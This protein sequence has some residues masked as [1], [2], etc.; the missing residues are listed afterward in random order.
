MPGAGR[1][2]HERGDD[3]LGAAGPQLLDHVQDPHSSAPRCHALVELEQPGR[4]ARRAE[5]ALQLL[6]AGAAERAPAQR[7]GGEDTDRFREPCDVVRLDQ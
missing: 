4:H 1:P 2:R 3:A 7:V 5:L 6:G